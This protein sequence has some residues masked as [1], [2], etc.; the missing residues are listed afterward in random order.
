MSILIPLAQGFEEI[1][2][3]TIIDILRRANLEVISAALTSNPVE[4]AHAISV[5]ADSEISQIK[6]EDVTAIVLPGG[7]PGSTNLR[8]DERI[9]SLVQTI[10]KQGKYVAAI[11]AAPIVLG[12]AGILQ[13]KKVTCF[14][15]MEDQLNGGIYTPDSICV[16]G[17]I[18]TG[19][20][21]GCA[22]DFS[23]MLVKVL[24]N[25][26]IFKQIKEAARVYWG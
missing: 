6:T 23:L 17:K 4:G 19:E 24:T 18:I 1:E 25:E 2:A 16:D 9:I 3:I 13:N 15:G 11:C 8:D 21:P 20:G 12:R 22:M 7:L 5:K 10:Y 14:P 26:T